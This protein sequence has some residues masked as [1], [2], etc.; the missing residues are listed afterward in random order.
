[1]DQTFPT[2][3]S[4]ESQV[5]RLSHLVDQQISRHPDEKGKH[6]SKCMHVVNPKLKI[7][8]YCQTNY[9]YL[10]NLLYLFP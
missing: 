9:I 2:S 4:I 6:S 10:Q 3:E 1:M 8:S 7:G 5:I